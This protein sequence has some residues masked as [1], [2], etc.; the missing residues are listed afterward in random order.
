VAAGALAACKKP[1]P[2][3]APAEEDLLLGA[4]E[5]QGGL[6]KLKAGSSFSARYKGTL[7][8]AKI[9]GTLQHRTGAMR[10]KYV[11]SSEDYQVTQVAADGLCWQRLDRVVIPC[12][13]PMRAHVTQL[14][15]LLEASWIWPLKE[16]KDRTVKQSKVKLANKVFAGLSVRTGEG[17]ELGTLL[18]DE[19]T[20][21]VEGLKMRTTLMGK[22][23][24]F[25]GFF[26]KFER[27]CG[28]EMPLQRQ[29][30]FMDQPYAT[31]E[32][33]GVVCE[34]V[35][36]KVFQRPAQVK[37]LEVDLKHTANIN[38]VCTKL[39]GPYA[40]IGDTI[41]KV[42]EFVIKKELPL[43]G[44]P[45]L[46]HRKGPPKVKNPA[47]YVTDVC[48][49]VTNKAWHLPKSTWSKKG[50]FLFERIGDEFLRVFGVGDYAKN[51][52][53]MAALLLKEA[54]K[55]KR[56]QV[57]SM[58]QFIYMHPRDY[59]VDQLVSEMQLPMN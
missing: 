1:A 30:T 5:T 56:T 21:R 20:Y 54:K 32:I 4:I 11:N 19:T 44:V 18:L 36:E 38:L 29:Y 28:L 26:S 50:F 41:T 59:P 25:V 8:G 15:R 52:P 58:V 47:R 10:L 13:K 34:A 3:P 9:K 37:H 42:Y 55:M 14:G 24:E 48:L 49:P 12:L 43:E 22:T 33:S 6:N 40:G 17:Q 45:V 7:M 27:N 51:T 57:A 31:E 35:D 53:V 2:P 39:K 23:G 46:V 16:R